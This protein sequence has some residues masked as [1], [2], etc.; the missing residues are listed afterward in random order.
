MLLGTRVVPR[1]WSCCLGTKPCKRCPLS[2]SDPSTQTAIYSTSL[3]RLST[4]VLSTLAL[5]WI[6]SKM[7]VSSP[8]CLFLLFTH[9]VCG[10]RS[11]LLL[12]AVNRP[13]IAK[14]MPEERHQCELSFSLGPCLQHDMT[15]WASNTVG[16]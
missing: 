4:H 10:H 1:L 8:M 14:H 9:P 3:P 6:C 5:I 2:G 16:V 12:R 7:T 13:L 15:P 11:A